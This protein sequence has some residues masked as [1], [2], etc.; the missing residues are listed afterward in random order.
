MYATSDY[1]RKMLYPVQK[2]RE[3]CASNNISRDNET[4]SSMVSAAGGLGLMPKGTRFLPDF[5]FPV[6]TFAT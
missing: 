3:I 1:E 2:S 4:L 5:V 6:L